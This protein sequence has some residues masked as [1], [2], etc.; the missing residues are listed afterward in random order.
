ME[1]SN[2]YPGLCRSDEYDNSIDGLNR[3]YVY[4][5]YHQNYARPNVN[6][7]FYTPRNSQPSYSQNSIA[8]SYY[9]PQPVP[10]PVP[11]VKIVTYT[12][13]SSS[14]PERPALTKINQALNSYRWDLLFKNFIKEIV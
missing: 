12:S 2:S 4:N 7:G 1:T 8:S 11:E 5:P 14:A 13:R 10:D 3:K 6:K 9:Q